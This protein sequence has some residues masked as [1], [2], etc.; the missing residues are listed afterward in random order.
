MSIMLPIGATRIGRR[1][2]NRDKLRFLIGYLRA[3]IYSCLFLVAATLFGF[4]QIVPGVGVSGFAGLVIVVASAYCA[5]SM[6][7][8][9][10]IL[11]KVLAQMAEPENL[12][13]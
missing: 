2:K 13:G 12:N 3:A 7:R 10:E 1:L 4:F 9:V 5:G 8:V 11:I 6:V